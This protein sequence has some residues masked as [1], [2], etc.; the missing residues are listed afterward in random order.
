MNV[1]FQSPLGGLLARP[2]VDPVGLFG[3]RRWY[4]PLSRLWAAANEASEGGA[5]FREQVGAWLGL[6]SALP[7]G[8]L[9]RSH[10]RVRDA[11]IAARNT[12]ANA[13]FGDGDRI[14]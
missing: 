8:G 1:L 9:L 4:M 2:W 7:L 11:A 14:A 6:W 10:V 12:W 13:V 3:L 5:L